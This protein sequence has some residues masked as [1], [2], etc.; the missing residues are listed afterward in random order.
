MGVYRL[1]ENNDCVGVAYR[2]RVDRGSENIGYGIQSIALAHS[3][4]APGSL[5]ISTLQT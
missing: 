5:G 2:K 3:S 1:N 4:H